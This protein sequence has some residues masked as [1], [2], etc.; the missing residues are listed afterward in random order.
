MDD[1]DR[2]PNCGDERPAGRT[3]GLRPLCCVPTASREET[4]TGSTS[5]AE[6]GPLANLEEGDPE[7]TRAHA[8]QPAPAEPTG[9]WSDVPGGPTRASP[10]PPAATPLTPGT[11]V[12]YFGDYE[13]RCELGRGG[14]GVVY[15]ARQVSL[16]R[17]VALKMI[18]A[19][20]LAGDDELRRFQNEAEAVA[21]LDHPGIVS[22]Y[23]VGEHGGQQ[24]LA[25]KLVRGQSLGSHLERFRDDPR[26]AA[27]LVAE[28]ADAVAHAHS[29]GILHRDLKPANILVDAEGHPH[30]TDFGLAKRL[31]ADMEMTASGAILG[32]PA[33][34]APEQASGRRGAITTATD[35]YGLGS[36]LY[37]LL[38]GRGPFG[39][40]TVV[41]TLDALRTRPPDP[42]SRINPKAPRDLETI[43]L[44]C[45]EKD[46][47][48]R[49][50]SA[51]GL[52]D[53][54]RAW[55]DSRPIAARRVGAA[56][57]AWLWCKR[58]PAVAA[59][60]AAVL[61]AI[62]GGTA[63][64]I[65]VQVNANRALRAKN[66]EL[67]I[68][69]DREARANRELAAAN[70]RVEQRYNLATDAI[71]T[72]H[73]GVSRDFLL[74]Q[75]QFR[76]LRDRL[77][78]S[79]QDFYSELSASLGEEADPASR[80]AL[81][82]ANFELADLTEKV[83]GAEDAL[84]AHRAVLA[85]RETLA[86]ER[87][88]DPALAVDLARSLVAVGW[89]LARTGQAGEA[90]GAYERAR[91]TLAAGDGGPPAGDDARSVFAEALTREGILS[92]RLGDFADALP[93]LEQARDLR[94]TLAAAAP[95]DTDRAAALARSLN[96]LGN[97]RRD[98][99][100]SSAALQT[101][102]AARDLWDSLARD[103][104]AVTQFR[105]DLAS[106][107]LN[108]GVALTD[109]GRPSEALRSY[110]AA[111]E[112]WETLVRDHPA[113]TQF[114]ADLAVCRNN[115]ATMLW[116][117]GQV[118]E[119]EAEYRAALAIY[120]KIVADNPTVGDFGSLLTTC[121]S[122]L[123]SLLSSIGRAPEA[124]AE[125]HAL[126]AT[127]ERL[128]ADRPADTGLRDRLTIAH[129][130]F[131]KYL[132]KHGRSAEAE[133]RRTIELDG[134]HIGDA[135]GD[136]GRLLIKA[137]R[138]DEAFKLLRG[139]LER[140]AGRADR[141]PGTREWIDELTTG[142]ATWGDLLAAA[143][144]PAGDPAYRE[145]RD[146]LA[147]IT[148]RNPSDHGA[149]IH[150]ATC[151][152]WLGDVESYQAHCLAMLGRFGATTDPQIA[153][154][155]SMIC[156]LDPRPHAG[157]ARAQALA[158]RALAATARP[159]QAF[160]WDATRALASYRAGRYA[161]ILERT[162]PRP[163][164][165]FG[166]ELLDE[167]LLA[168]ASEREGRPAEARLWLDLARSACTA[169]EPYQNA[170]QIRLLL[171][172]AEAL[173]P[174]RPDDDE[175]P[176]GADEIRLRRDLVEGYSHLAAALEA[177]GL[178]READAARLRM[179]DIGLPADPFAAP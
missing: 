174:D 112:L 10:N 90:R 165:A 132:Q 109:M 95:A 61:I 87:A 106:S 6:R 178:R 136:L 14:M 19:G 171:R 129:Y 52:A 41:E 50:A 73:T 21:L 2:C 172:E 22:A 127:F 160:W 164:G 118:R 3:E 1:G 24:Y 143:G 120:G 29:R 115:L 147:R 11:T 36:I 102:Q 33:Y 159:D 130:L 99:G 148:E 85:A 83:G 43:C 7:V 71:K 62:V 8:G 135:V 153:G 66:Q 107:N 63:A 101:Y 94:T 177:K 32:T 116:D 17:P 167:L 139:L 84:A 173:I 76:E 155:I 117:T 20:L 152:L 89:A 151:D 128:A 25:M 72:F 49:Y 92:H 55:L 158:E 163:G 144:T 157:W 77:L 75:D 122:N 162:P 156:L 150:L 80:R 54:L 56:E 110:E 154:R 42:P 69:N 53:D 113:V 111:R 30:V 142:Y 40:D 119:A 16:N 126:L 45:L 179:L 31:E 12:R 18:K 44:K 5:D 26:A 138:A 175:T 170:T 70:R 131:G 57:R 28:A 137:G 27:S 93:L 97:L 34:M 149:W 51:Q 37:T 108:I 145:V 168:M 4:A 134:D 124:D 166:A 60:S 9:D 74:R 141:E 78:R 86:A 133:F 98:S 176:L 100:Q 82:Q 65:A 15:E 38:T 39:G 146:G 103:H 123:A 35:V 125:Y 68:A 105:S 47:R 81:A 67:T 114:Q 79:A 91:K 169:L 48:R 23:E 104:P 58:R 59:L 121:V 13:I 140:L 64:T 46:P 161:E 96:S 88:A